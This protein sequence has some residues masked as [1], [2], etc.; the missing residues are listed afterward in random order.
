MPPPRRAGALLVA[1]AL[2]ATACGGDGAEPDESLAATTTE[3][4]SGY[5]SDVDGVMAGVNAAIA[6]VVATLGGTYAEQS[7]LFGAFG[8][9]ELSTA[10][11]IAR[12][13]A[14]LLEPPEEFESDHETFLATLTEAATTGERITSAIDD[15]DIVELAAAVAKLQTLQGGLTQR[16]SPEL[17][18]AVSPGLEEGGLDTA[19]KDLCVAVDEVGESE[20]AQGTARNARRFFIEVAP[21]I[22][23][24]EPSF[25]DKDTIEYLT[26]IQPEVERILGELAD[27]QSA[28]EPPEA[29]AEDHEQLVQFFV[30][31][32]GLARRIS[33]AAEEGDRATLDELFAESGQVLDAARASL[34]P[35]ARRIIAPMFRDL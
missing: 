6:D 22:G 15:R 30:D 16:V 17:C 13:D 27:A 18:E 29:R 34:A 11:E 28:L 35:E 24:L 20:W 26:L 3:A 14:E 1:L 19:W 5:V 23:G 33:A 25:T 7:A 31:F 8:T 9:A 12:N 32:A 2:L 10:L 4:S 21:R